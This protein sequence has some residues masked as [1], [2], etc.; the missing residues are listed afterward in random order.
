MDHQTIYVVLAVLIAAGLHLYLLCRL[1]VK[2]A[3]STSEKLINQAV[4]SDAKFVKLL[5]DLSVA[6]SAVGTQL[7]SIDHSMV[8]QSGEV[9]KT[10]E[11]NCKALS[12]SIHQSGK[13]QRDESKE[14]AKEV[15]SSSDSSSARVSV[16]SGANGTCLAMRSTKP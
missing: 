14:V 11:L 5:Q 2:A 16:M 3:E 1:I 8:Q 10:L 15:R 9:V 12:D 4:Q 6:L 7:K 13:G